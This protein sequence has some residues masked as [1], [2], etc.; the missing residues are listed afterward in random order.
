MLEE[1]RKY[2]VIPVASVNSVD[3]GLRLCEALLAAELSI[4]EVTFRT[5]A[6]E[7]TIAAVSQRFPEMLV[8]AGTILNTTDVGRAADAGARFAV[9]PGLNPQVVEAALAREF[10][11]FPGVATPSDV[12]RGLGLGLKILKFFPAGAMGGAK[13]LKSMSAP[14]AHLGVQYVPTG[15][16]SLDNMGDYLALPTVAAVGGS[17]MASKDLIGAGDWQ[18]VET[19]AR[20]ARELAGA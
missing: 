3:D 17:W 6:A 9:S 4:I 14:Y 20:E 13:Y 19:C 2:R 7:A 16:V 12:E 18:G 11:F 10:A 15:G 1:L 5:E 8:G